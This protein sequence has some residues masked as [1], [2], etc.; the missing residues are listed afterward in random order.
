MHTFEMR[1]LDCLIRLPQVLLPPRLQDLRSIRFGTA[2]YIPPVLVDIDML[3]THHKFVVDSLTF[4]HPDDLCKWPQACKTLASMKHLNDLH[5]TL[6]LR[7][8]PHR[9]R[10]AEYDEYLI[11]LLGHLLPIRALEYG[12]FLEHKLS[13]TV[14]ARLGSLPFQVTH[15]DDEF[16]RL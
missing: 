6:E 15:L 4:R 5:I 3:P 8:G 2:L 11:I 1:R 13:R 14:M 12:V 9:P 7:S 16:R 10:R